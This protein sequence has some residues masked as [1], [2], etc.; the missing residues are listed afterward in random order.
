VALTADYSLAKNL[1]LH[2]QAAWFMGDNGMY[3]TTATTTPGDTA[4]EY[5]VMLGWYF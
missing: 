4:S 1:N 2:L 3:D 5:L